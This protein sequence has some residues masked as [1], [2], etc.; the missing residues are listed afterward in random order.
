MAFYSILRD[1]LRE[2]ENVRSYERCATG[3]ICVAELVSFR[4]LTG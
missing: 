1:K 2:V 4:E 3:F